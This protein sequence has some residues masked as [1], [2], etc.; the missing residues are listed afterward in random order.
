MDH[1][2]PT[3][4]LR[5]PRRARRGDR[6]A[7]N[8]PGACIRRP[9]RPATPDQMPA[10]CTWLITPTVRR[11][12]GVPQGAE[13]THVE[14]PAVTALTRCTRV[15][16]GGGRFPGLKWRWWPAIRVCIL[17]PDGNAGRWELG[18]SGAE[19]RTIYVSDGDLP[20]YQ[21]AQ[22]LAGGNLSSAIHR[23]RCAA[24]WMSR[25]VAARASRRSPFAWGPA[26]G[27]SASAASSSASGPTRRG[28]R[29]TAC[30][31]LEPASSCFTRE[32]PGVGEP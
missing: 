19:T 3:I 23:G 9:L 2:P 4:L 26:A 31:R 14:L 29:S 18:C 20:L 17:V 30:T 16:P 13:S 25:T 1:L 28:A 10:A 32:V 11:S 21:R 22:E 8:I 15:L 6:A 5:R 12:P 24:T 7:R 27:S